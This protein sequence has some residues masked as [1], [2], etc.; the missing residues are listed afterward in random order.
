MRKCAKE[1]DGQQRV[2][3]EENRPKRADGDVV[4]NSVVDLV[5]HCPSQDRGPSGPRSHGAWSISG[6]FND[7]ATTGGAG[8]MPLGG[9]GVPAS[10]LS[11][12]VLPDNGLAGSQL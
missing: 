2:G 4:Q 10:A 12:G 1:R 6:R 8:T 3:Y 9:Y 7:C 5:Q 11:V